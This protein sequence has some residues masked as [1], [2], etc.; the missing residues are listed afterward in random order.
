VGVRFRAP[1]TASDNDR[2]WPFR[3]IRESPLT[4]SVTGIKRSIALSTGCFWRWSLFAV[5]CA[6]LVI[7]R[8]AFERLAAPALEELLFGL[9]GAA[10]GPRVTWAPR[11]CRAYSR[12]SD[13]SRLG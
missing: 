5:A 12:S 3:E 8:D 10:I 13:V 7:A 11:I 4:E 2:N 6:A 9:L 1:F